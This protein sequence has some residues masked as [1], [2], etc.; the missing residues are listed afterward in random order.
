MN[1]KSYLYSYLL[2]LIGGILLVVLQGRADLFKAITIIV[3]ILFLIPG[4]MSLIRAVFPPKSAKLAGEKP[5]AGLIIVS[6]AAM[7]F[8][9]VLIAAPHIFINFMVYAFGTLLIICGI[10]QLMNFMPAINSLGFPKLYL[11]TPILSLC[12][13][14]LVMVIG[15]EKILNVLAL[16]TGIVLI[17]Y[18][19]N[20][21]AGYFDRTKRLKGGGVTG[22]IVN[23]E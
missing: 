3:G 19:L 5:S 6:A 11:A 22:K 16:V 1:N 15:A 17:V 10:V 20:G 7:I 4:L 2:T 13:G 9:I 8:G 14:I 23:V 12:I 21:L 18:S